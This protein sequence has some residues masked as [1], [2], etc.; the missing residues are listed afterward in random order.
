MSLRFPRL[1]IAAMLCVLASPAALAGDLITSVKGKQV[2][3]FDTPDDAKP[4][5]KVDVTGLPWAIKEEKNAFF[6]VNVGGKDGWVDSMQVMVPR[7]AKSDCAPRIGMHQGK[8]PDNNA[9]TPGA[10]MTR[11]P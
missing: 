11:C 7:S 6:K 10:A 1:A 4:G 3:L 5:R 8:V 9:A 2:E